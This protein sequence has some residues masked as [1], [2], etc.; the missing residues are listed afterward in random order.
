MQAM[1]ATGGPVSQLRGGL[2]SWSGKRALPRG[3]CA[4][5]VGVARARGCCV[6]HEL[7][8]D[9]GPCSADGR[10]PGRERGSHAGDVNGAGDEVAGAVWRRRGR[11]LDRA[12]RAALGVSGVVWGCCAAACLAVP[13]HV[14]AGVL[15][16]G[17]VDGLVVGF[18]LPAV[19]LGALHLG[20][21]AAAVPV[22]AVVRALGGVAGLG[23]AGA[24]LVLARARGGP[25]DRALAGALFAA[26]G[27]LALVAAEAVAAGAL[28]P[29]G[30]MA[31]RVLLA[32]AYALA[33]SWVMCGAAEGEEWGAPVERARSL[34]PPRRRDA[35]GTSVSLAAADWGL[36]PAVG[37]KSGPP[38]PRPVGRGWV[39]K[40]ARKPPERY[41]EM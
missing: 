30:V 16:G 20:G 25:L 2:P 1:L 5:A 33:A 40:E 39:R 8:E 4:S 31:V 12:R 6:S 15:P 38:R 36:S 32:P 22:A 3:G 10:V 21:W 14:A 23:I 24:Q 13:G 35:R 17:G 27:G 37:G 9:D 41:L 18:P 7:W 11:E 29:A 26:T 19:F 28:T 34:S